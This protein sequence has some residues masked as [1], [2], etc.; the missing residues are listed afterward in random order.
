[1]QSIRLVPFLLPFVVAVGGCKSV[2]QYQTIASE[3]PE[4]AAANV[5]V[6][7]K[8]AYVQRQQVQMVPNVT[9]QARFL[10]VKR[11]CANWPV[12]GSRNAQL[13][14]FPRLG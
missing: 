2:H 7:E 13:A 1:M 12:M 5:V 3:S 11:K 8:R 6:C 10:R 9:A 14:G 4:L